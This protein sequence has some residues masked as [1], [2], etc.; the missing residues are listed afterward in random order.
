MLM[1]IL[2]AL[3]FL[4][5]WAL[6]VRYFYAL[7][8]LAGVS[9]IIP[10]LGPLLTVILAGLVAA[11]DS[12]LKV[13]GVLIFYLI[14]QQAEEAYLTPRIMESTVDLP[15]VAVVVALAVGGGL[16]GILGALVAVPSAALIG[17]VI[18]EYMLACD[19]PEEVEYRRAG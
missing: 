2:G 16:A 10:I 5:F 11:T 19:R 6:G 18:N 13:L 9:N 7:A 4:A 8:L 3:S 15:A 14:Y 1:L 17:T 12:G